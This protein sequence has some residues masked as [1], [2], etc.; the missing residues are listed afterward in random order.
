MLVYIALLRD[1]DLDHDEIIGVRPHFDL[2][3][4][5]IKAWYGED[6]RLGWVEITADNY[7]PETLGFYRFKVDYGTDR[8]YVIRKWLEI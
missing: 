8:V 2:L 3:E 6:Q 1:L 4:Q 5:D 7:E